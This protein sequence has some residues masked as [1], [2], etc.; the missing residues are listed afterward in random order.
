[1]QATGMLSLR[2]FVA[3]ISSVP[4]AF[5]HNRKKIKKGLL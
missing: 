5:D 4:P 1:M 2:F 3:G